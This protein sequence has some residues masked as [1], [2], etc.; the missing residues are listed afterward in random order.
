MGLYKRLTDGM[1]SATARCR[2]KNKSI[3]KT[4]KPWLPEPA[5]WYVCSGCVAVVG[6]DYGS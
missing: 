5:G 2:T 6:G 1:C 4:Y 3:W